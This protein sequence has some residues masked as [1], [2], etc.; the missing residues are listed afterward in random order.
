MACCSR[1]SQS[2]E[3][4]DTL[5]EKCQKYRYAKIS[6]FLRTGQFCRYVG[7][8]NFENTFLLQ[9]LRCDICI[10][11]IIAYTTIYGIW[12]LKDVF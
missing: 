8:G 12:N 3:T 9:I 6:Q 1:L 2:C 10:I 11:V 5:T 4:F 7:I